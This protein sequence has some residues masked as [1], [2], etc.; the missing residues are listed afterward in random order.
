LKGEDTTDYTTYTSG[1]TLTAHTMTEIANVTNLGGFDG[2]ASEQ[3]ITHLRSRAKQFFVGLQ[4]F[5]NVTLQLQL[6]NSDVGQKKLRALK[7]SQSIGTFSITL[8]N[9]EVTAFRAYVK[10]FTFNDLTPDGI[11]A[12][13]VT[14]RVT[15]EPAW[16]A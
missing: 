4:D 2:E 13:S 11:V 16:F 14:L 8:S 7:R 10:S 3:D 6:I 9:G 12:G 5:G 1:G 15:G